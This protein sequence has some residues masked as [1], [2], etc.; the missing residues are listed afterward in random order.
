MTIVYYLIDYMLMRS[1]II[2]HKFTTRIKEK[3]AYK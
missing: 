1:I 2:K 3:Q